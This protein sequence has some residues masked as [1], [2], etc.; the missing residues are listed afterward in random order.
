MEFKKETYSSQVYTYL[1]ELIRRGELLPGEPVKEAVIADK[2]DISRAPI[3][4]ALQDMLH[5]GLLTSEPQKGKFVHVLTK[6]EII[7]SYALAGMLEG[8]G[9]SES[10]A[11]WSAK[12]MDELRSI[13][14]DMRQQARTVSDLT[15][16]MHFDD[17]FH[18][19]LLQH[20]DNSKLVSMARMS[21][22]TISKILMYRE[23][24]QS[25]SPEIFAERHASI[26]EAMY[27]MKPEKVLEVLQGHYRE[28]GERMAE[29]CDNV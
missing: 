29:R 7:D 18:N 17:V 10:L 24:L 23:W 4:E 11:A 28:L 25:Y 19:A 14:A 13:I 8:M 27:T 1:T 22:V 9:V 26:A 20:C 5:Q 6:K 3:R 21:C 12:D 16:L 15:D 2:L